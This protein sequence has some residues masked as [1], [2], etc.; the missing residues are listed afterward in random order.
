MCDC[1]WWRMYKTETIVIEH[2][3]ETFPYKKLLREKILGEDQIWN[4]NWLRST[5]Y[6]STRI[7]PKTFLPTFPPSSRTLMFV[8]MTLFCLRKKLPMK[9]DFCF[10]PGECYFQA[11]SCR[12]ALL[13]GIGIVC[14]KVHRFVYYP[15]MKFFNIFVQSAVNARREEDENPNSSFVADRLKLLANSSYGYQFLDRSRHTVT[16][17]LEDGKIR[18][19]INSKNFSGVWLL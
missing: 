14:I 6:W 9:N 4:S 17:Y 2:L 7:F 10:S 13:S 16:K 5:W 8:G 18:R 12:A 11:F 1:N 15:P 19:A 3:L